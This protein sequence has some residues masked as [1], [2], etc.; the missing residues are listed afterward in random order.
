MDKP[1]KEYLDAIAEGRRHHLS[2][3]T[4][5][6]SFL[7]PHKPYLSELIER[8]GIG[9][10][11][12]IGAGKGRQYE[13]RDPLDGKTLEQGWGFDVAKHDPCWPPFEAEPQ[14]QY[15]L[16]I[17]THTAS[18]IPAGDLKWFIKRIASHAGR[19][20]YLAEKNRAA[21]KAGYQ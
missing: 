17:C 20:V 6:G 3:K 13:W 14:G 2:S 19:A 4:Y 1:S 5:S 10:A 16:V 21:P 9:S 18:I 11:L 8:L 12:D 15:D 7:R